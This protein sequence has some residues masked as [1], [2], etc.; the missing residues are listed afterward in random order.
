MHPFGFHLINVLLQAANAL[1]FWKLLSRLS[2]PGA[3]WA[4]AV[5]AL[6]PVHVM[7][8]AWVTELKNVLS[9]CFYLAGLLMYLKICGLDGDRPAQ[10]GDRKRFYALTMGLFLCALLSKTSTSIFPVAILLILWWKRGRIERKELVPILPFFLIGVAFGVFTLWLEKHAKGASGQGFTLSFVERLLVAGHSFWFSLGKLAWPTRLTFIYPRWQIDPKSV[11]QYLFPVG[12]VAL[13]VT[14]WWMR[15]RIGRAPFAALLYFTI[16]FPALVMV[17]MLYMMRYSFVTD[18]WQYLG[19]MSM[20]P[21]G[22]GGA[23]LALR[24]FPALRE[25][26]PALGMLVL[27]I[28]GLLTWQQGHIYH[29]LETLWRDT[30][31]KNP[32]AWLAHNNLGVELK[33]RGQIPEAI[34][35]YQQALQ[36]KPDFAEAHYNLGNILLDLGQV[37]EAIRHYEQA[38]QSNPVYPEAHYN[39]GVALERVGRIQEAIGHYQQAL[40]I[41]PDYAEAHYNLGNILFGLGKTSEA[42]AHYEQALRIDPAYAEAHCNLGNALLRAGDTDNAIRHYEQ[43]LRLRPD[44]VDAHNNLASVLM[45]EGK[46]EEAIG[47]WEKAVRIRPDFAEAHYNLGIALEQAGRRQEAITHYEEALKINPHY[48]EAQ[49][50]LAHLRAVQ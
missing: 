9:G 2:V 13:L 41:K 5:F 24:R 25:Q 1:L 46:I 29:D 21:L 28:L 18:H 43:A 48:T 47:H 34:E 7:S 32:N 27:A 17:Q 3:W 12:A 45:Q 50:R 4:A 11:W 37:P 36:I 49:N 30:L 20:I 16:A 33:N 44:Y 14:A 22:V 35:Q 38:L 8:V 19:S 31:A 23:A 10:P 40:L 26:K 39:L 42:I 15:K 6:H